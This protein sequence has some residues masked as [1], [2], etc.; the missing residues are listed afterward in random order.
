[1]PTTDQAIHDDV[2][3]ALERAPGI[4]ES[5]IRVV[6]ENGDVYLSGWVRSETERESA[7]DVAHSVEGVRSVYYDDLEVR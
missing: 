4:D 7:H 5:T 3:E 6:V 1:M 2:H